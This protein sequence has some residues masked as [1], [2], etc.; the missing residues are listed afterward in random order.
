MKVAV[1]LPKHSPMFGHEASSQ[2]VC[3]LRL[4][5]HALDL[6][7]ALALRDPHADPV[8]LAATPAPASTLIGM[9]AVLAAAALRRRASDGIG[10]MARQ[11]IASGR[12]A[13]RRSASTTA[14]AVMLTMRRTV[15]DGVRMC[16]GRAAPS[17]MPP[18]VMPLPAAMR[19]RL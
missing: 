17:R 18:T 11:S 15:D 19:S 14:S 5:Q 13:L 16:T 10:L 1:P 3:R 9:R 12:G 4:A 7:E 6:A 8:G 2:T